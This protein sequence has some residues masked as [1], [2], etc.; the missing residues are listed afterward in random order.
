MVSTGIASTE[1]S[2]LIAMRENRLQ[3]ERI[4]AVV[5]I[6][7]ASGAAAALEYLYLTIMGLAV[8]YSFSVFCYLN[9]RGYRSFLLFVSSSIDVSAISLA[10]LVILTCSGD[11]STASI[12]FTFVYAAY[13]PAILLSLR[14]YDPQNG[15]FAGSLASIQ[16][17]F[18]VATFRYSQVFL[19]KY[20]PGTSSWLQNVAPCELFKGLLLFLTGVLAFT[21]A[22]DLTRRLQSA[23]RTEGALRVEEAYLTQF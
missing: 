11:P 18:I 8:L 9:R 17:L 3:V 13:F 5:R 4:V 7:L 1:H 19:F 22:R 10:V 16:Y 23:T 2:F 21:L 12:G 15:L 20:A 6:V 14:R